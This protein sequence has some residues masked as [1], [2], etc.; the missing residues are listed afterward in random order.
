LAG[1]SGSSSVSANAG[2]AFAGIPVVEADASRGETE[3]IS[4]KDTG[5][6]GVCSVEIRNGKDLAVLKQ[7]TPYQWGRT[8]SARLREEQQWAIVADVKRLKDGLLSRQSHAC[9]H[10]FGRPV[11]SERQRLPAQTTRIVGL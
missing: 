2:A 7:F 11:D 1:L 9:A 6:V 8:N 10:R 3:T 5:V 4:T